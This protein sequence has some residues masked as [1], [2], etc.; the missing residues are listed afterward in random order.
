MA[1]A[2]FSDQNIPNKLISD[3]I[4]HQVFEYKIFWTRCI[5]YFLWI[6]ISDQFIPKKLFRVQKFS[7]HQVN[8]E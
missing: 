7:K 3:S 6:K 2:I 8:N 5:G 1:E 4:I